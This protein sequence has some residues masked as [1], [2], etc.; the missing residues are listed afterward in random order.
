MDSGIRPVRPT[1][2]RWGKAIFKASSTK[3]PRDTLFNHQPAPLGTPV[4]LS[5]SAA[6][7]GPRPLMTPT[8]QG[9]VRKSMSRRRLAKNA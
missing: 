9:S 4:R 8:G 7:T 5:D 3:V 2:V 6:K 1:N